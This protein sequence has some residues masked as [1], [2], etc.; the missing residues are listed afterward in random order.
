M[1]TQI[2]RSRSGGFTLV[3]VLVAMSVMM[4]L[5]LIVG[6]PLAKFLQRSKLTGAVQQTASLMRLARIHAIK[7]SSWT[8][9]RIQP[10]ATPPHATAFVDM[11]RDRQFDSGEPVL[12]TVLL[13]R[14]ITFL[15][16]DGF[17][18]FQENGGLESSGDFRFTDA[19][20]NEMEVRVEQAATGKIGI[21]KYENGVCIKRGQGGEVWTWK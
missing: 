6:P 3:E 20:G 8:A 2:E 1:S 12:G 17:A 10:A 7:R 16:P 11:D 19:K 4:I 21:C 18:V 13:E 5:M 9:V 14:G 15:A